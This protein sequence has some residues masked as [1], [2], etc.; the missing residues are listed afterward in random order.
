MAIAKVSELVGSSRL[1]WTDAVNN[2]VM[3][4]SEQ[5]GIFGVE[6]TNFTANIKDGQI[7]EYRANIKIVS[8]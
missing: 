3:E 4:A 8:H 1:N 6:V 7:K 5:D 2:A